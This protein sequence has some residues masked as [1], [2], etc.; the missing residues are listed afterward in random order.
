MK[1]TVTRSSFTNAMRESFTYEAIQALWNYF[2]QYESDTGE[3]LE[4]DPIAF[5]CEFNEYSNLE[6]FHEEYDK[7]EYPTIEDIEN[8]T[9]VIPFEK[10]EGFL[11]RGFQLIYNSRSPILAPPST[12]GD[13]S[14][15]N[16]YNPYAQRATRALA[17]RVR[18][19]RLSNSK[20]ITIHN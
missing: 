3:E 13:P 7:E 2:E 20:A 1:D 11:I 5:R 17:S 14:Q 16:W 18:V 19:Q 10:T 15:S 4:L 9:T 6:E 12:R 8:N